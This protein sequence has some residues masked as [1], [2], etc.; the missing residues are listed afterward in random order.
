MC[1]CRLDMP[2]FNSWH[3]CEMASMRHRKWII[4][5]EGFNLLCMVLESD[6]YCPI[7]K[8]GLDHSYNIFLFILVTIATVDTTV[9]YYLHGDLCITVEIRIMRHHLVC[10]NVG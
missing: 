4:C 9:E 1:N 8:K 7:K 2:F 5:V 3:E 6:I 10:V